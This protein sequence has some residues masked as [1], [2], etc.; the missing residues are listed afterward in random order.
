MNPDHSHNPTPLAAAERRRHPRQAARAVLVIAELDGHGAP[1]APVAGELVDLSRSGA[2]IR[3]RRPIADGR[4][5]VMVFRVPGQ[6]PRVLRG[7][8]RNCR[9]IAQGHYHV[10]VE[11]VTP[12]TPEPLTEWAAGLA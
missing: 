11:F 1:G 2:G 5:I 6:A 7:V 8:A 3:G 4:P 10:G 12:V 9:Y